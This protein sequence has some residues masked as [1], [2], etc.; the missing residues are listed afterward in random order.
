MNEEKK[1]FEQLVAEKAD[2]FEF[3]WNGYVRLYEEG[4]KPC[5]CC[6]CQAFY[7][8]N[9]ELESLKND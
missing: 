6:A 5:E 2:C 4:Q 1:S 3:A 7:K 9:F 8:L